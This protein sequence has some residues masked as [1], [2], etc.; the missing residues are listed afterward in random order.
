MRRR[1]FIRSIGAAGIGITLAGC[2]G[3][4]G[5]GG[6]SDGG[7]DGGGSDGGGSD[8]GDGGDGGDGAST[9]GGS[10]P[11]TIGVLGPKSGPLSRLN[12][13]YTANIDLA[14]DQ[15]NNGGNLVHDGGGIDVGGTTRDVEYVYYDTESKPNVG[16]SAAE[17]LIEQDGVSVIL[18]AMSST[19]T[20]AI[21]DVLERE[22]VPGITSVS[23]NEKIT[24][25]EGH[26]WMF[27]NKDTDSMR[28]KYISQ[29]IAEEIGF[30]SVGMI[31]PNN[32]FG[33]GRMDAFESAL[34]DNGVETLTKQSFNQEAQSFLAELESIKAEEPDALYMVLNDPT[35]GVQMVPQARQVGFENMVGTGPLGTPDTP[36]KVGDPLEGTH[37]EITFPNEAKGSAEHVTQWAN[38][39]EAATDGQV[40][41]N[42]IG[43]PTY[44]AIN[45]IADS[46]SRAGE[47]A[48]GPIRDAMADASV[49][50]VFPYPE[51]TLEFNE[52]NQAEVVAGIGQWQKDGGE[53][54]LTVQTGPFA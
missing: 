46:V 48:P 13:F 12:S 49:M 44:D 6:N 25:S 37:I 26:D 29:A 41:P 19:T 4:G 32:D 42:Y 8:G 7:S 24:G 27:R 54:S 14:I 51:F 16:V 50:G 23:V 31:A 15:I 5:D 40:P 9:S 34:G 21:M 10:G 33:I 1:S 35:H 52:N 43:A 39:L 53:W 18:G 28:A 3:D 20:L 11:V 30:G 22:Q 17:R 47:V 38:D 2:S 45:A 36:E